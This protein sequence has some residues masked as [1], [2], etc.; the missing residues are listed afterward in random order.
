[1][2]IRSALLLV[3]IFETGGTGTKE[4]WTVYQDRPGLREYESHLA[5]AVHGR[6]EC[7]ERPD[8]P[9]QFR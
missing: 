2:F 1:M 5:R 3:W 8:L 9:R 4:R 7:V 6:L